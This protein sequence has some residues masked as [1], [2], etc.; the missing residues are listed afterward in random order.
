MK[1]LVQFW[2][3]PKEIRR[4]IGKWH[5]LFG[6]FLDQ[7]VLAELLS[8]EAIVFLTFTASNAG[9]GL[10]SVL[11]SF[12]VF[13]PVLRGRPGCRDEVRFDLRFVVVSTFSSS[14]DEGSASRVMSRP[15]R[16]TAKYHNHYNTYYY[17]CSYC[18]Y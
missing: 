9:A 3:T 16:F 6:R 14:S 4:Q 7:I 13:V 17:Y 1:P 11:L 12:I 2:L 8:V 10:T 15:R 5:K 18:C